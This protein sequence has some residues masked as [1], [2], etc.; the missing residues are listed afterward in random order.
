MKKVLAL[1]VWLIMTT[2]GIASVG[3]IQQSRGG[4]HVV[5]GADTLSV[6]KSFK[7]EKADILRT[8]KDGWVKIKLNDNTLITAGKNAELT[9]RDYLYDK[10]K[11][12]KVSLGFSKGIF[13]AISG[14]IG[15][16]ARKNFKVHTPTATIGIR[17]TEFYVRVS[18]KREQVLCTRGAVVFNN[19]HREI[20]I[21]AGHQILADLISQK[22]ETGT[23]STKDLGSIQKNLSLS[24]QT[25]STKKP[26][27]VLKRSTRGVLTK[28]TQKPSSSKKNRDRNKKP[29]EGKKRTEERIHEQ[30][31]SAEI[32]NTNP[33]VQRPCDTVKP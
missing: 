17:G 12:S 2:Y 6:K 18:S 5:R 26:G 1:I 29:F 33:I 16:V 8:S 31:T 21:N 4:V 32:D 30:I 3:V 9:I 22:L 24:R 11:K 23:F 7:L 27:G 25:S 13:R 15:K 14:A 10:S 19:A 28:K 20:V